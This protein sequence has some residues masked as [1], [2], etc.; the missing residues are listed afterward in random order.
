MSL[1]LLCAVV[2]PSVV[3]CGLLW[4]WMK[5]IQEIGK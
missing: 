1:Y 5:R 2:I 3:L 4:Q